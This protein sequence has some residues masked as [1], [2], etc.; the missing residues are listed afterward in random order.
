MLRGMTGG[1]DYRK[2]RGDNQEFAKSL[3]S[4]Y[5]GWS[6]HS[7]Y[8]ILVFDGLVMIDDMSAVDADISF[9]LLVGTK[10]LRDWARC[11]WKN[12][13]SDWQQEGHRHGIWLD[14]GSYWWGTFSATTGTCGFFL[15]GFV[16][17]DGWYSWPLQG[18]DCADVLTKSEW[19]ILLFFL[20]VLG[21]MGHV[22]CVF[23]TNAVC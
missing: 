3:W 15:A 8:E 9:T 23:W 4:S 7:D 16:C 6:L 20:L 14:Q 17:C 21:R 22:S 13:H 12:G 11:H 19:H 2:R 5:S 1:F 10:R 18:I